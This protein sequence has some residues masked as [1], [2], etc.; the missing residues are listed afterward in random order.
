MCSGKGSAVGA[1]IAAVVFLV[2]SAFISIGAMAGS[3][4]VLSVPKTDFPGGSCTE[5]SITFFAT[6][7]EVLVGGQM[8]RTTYAEAKC[9]PSLLSATACALVKNAVS[10]GGAAVRRRRPLTSGLCTPPSTLSRHPR[11]P[12][13]P[14]FARWPCLLLP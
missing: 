13:F 8:T 5:Q 7:S 12:S 4:K 10:N 2:L 11:A 6:A 14:H 9:D 1:E 3:Y